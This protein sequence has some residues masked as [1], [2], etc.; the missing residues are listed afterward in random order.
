MTPLCRR[1]SRRDSTQCGK[2]GGISAAANDDDGAGEARWRQADTLTCC[3]PARCS[4]RTIFYANSDFAARDHF[5]ADSRCRAGSQRIRSSGDLAACLLGISVRPKAPWNHIY[6]SKGDHNGSRPRRAP[7][8]NGRNEDAG[9]VL[10]SLKIKV[11][12]SLDI[13]DLG[14]SGTFEACPQCCS[15]VE[16]KASRALDGPDL[17]VVVDDVSET[18]LAIPGRCVMATSDQE[19]AESFLSTL[20]GT[21]A[22]PSAQASRRPEVSRRSAITANFHPTPTKT[23][24]VF[25]QS[26]ANPPV[27]NLRSFGNFGA[28]RALPINDGGAPS[29]LMSGGSV[30]MA[31]KTAAAESA[32][33]VK[34]EGNS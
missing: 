33:G 27:T 12:K 34:M 23:P 32:L 18:L 31:I 10:S 19:S 29:R 4:V 3:H 21:S 30:L 11:A 17:G 20:C 7:Q 13:P 16:A 26:L 5:L 14:H 25:G 6:Q 24:T 2:G 15:S 8:R 22:F 9:S 1:W 28:N